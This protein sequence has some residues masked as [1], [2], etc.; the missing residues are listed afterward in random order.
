MDF[1]QLRAAMI[2]AVAVEMPDPVH[3]TTI[4]GRITAIIYRRNEK[5]KITCSAEISETGSVRFGAVLIIALIG[6]LLMGVAVWIA[7]EA[8]D[9]RG[10]EGTEDDAVREKY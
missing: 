9:K 10:K 4:R 5:G 7:K 3:R 1:F 2:G 8:D 6:L